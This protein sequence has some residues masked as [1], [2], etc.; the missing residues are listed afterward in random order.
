MN[1]NNNEKCNNAACSNNPIYSYHTFLFPFTWR[2]NGLTSHNEYSEIKS[3]FKNV[4]SWERTEVYDDSM[5]IKKDDKDY[6]KKLEFY[7]E[8]QYFFP[9][10]RKAVFNA[11]DNWLSYYG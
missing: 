1:E 10:V 6:G 3:M 8:Y 9:Y 11:P 4:S 5:T 7:K 2:G